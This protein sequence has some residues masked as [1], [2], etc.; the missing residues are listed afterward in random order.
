MIEHWNLAV[1]G[2]INAG[3]APPVWLKG[4]SIFSAE[5]LIYFLPVWMVFAWVR[6]ATEMRTGLIVATFATLLGLGVNQLIA[7]FWY[8]P[9]PFEMG[10]GYTLIPHV[11]ET[12][13]PS[14]HAVVFFSVGLSL[15]WL[16]ATR[17][18]GILISALGMLVAWSRVYIGVH[19][20][21]DML[22]SFVISMLVAL[23]AHRAA[24]ITESVLEPFFARLYTVVIRALHL[25]RR[26]FPD[27]QQR[28]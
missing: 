25:P 20:P 11:A 7:L 18:W 16:R 12:S 27:S 13:F 17:G 10:V 8:H 14:D 1:F 15:W 21:L 24:P 6:G 2:L 26:W 28:S 23:A 19:F 5:A 22:G 4:F 9:R 3:A